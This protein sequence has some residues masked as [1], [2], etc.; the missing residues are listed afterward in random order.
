MEPVSNQPLYRSRGNMVFKTRLTLT[1][2]QVPEPSR[3]HHLAIS[4]RKQHEGQM[5]AMLQL[6]MQICSRLCH[7]HHGALLDRSKQVSELLL[8]GLANEVLATTLSGASMRS[9]QIH[10]DH[11]VSCDMLTDQGPCDAYEVQSRYL[12]SGAT[13]ADGGRPAWTPTMKVSLIIAVQQ[14]MDHDLS[15]DTADCIK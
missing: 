9:P 8:A 7:L 6:V 10:R 5:I 14:S 13:T 1:A 4:T 3:L 11:D 15:S 2:R 12:A